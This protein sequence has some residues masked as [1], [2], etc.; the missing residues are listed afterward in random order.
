MYFAS[1]G[2]W[3]ELQLPHQTKYITFLNTP[4]DYVDLVSQ[5]PVTPFLIGL[6]YVIGLSSVYQTLDF[7][8]FF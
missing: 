4:Q 8:F 3:Q 6:N 2:S 1:R 7:F 5:T